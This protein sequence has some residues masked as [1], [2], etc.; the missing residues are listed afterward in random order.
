[1]GTD[2]QRD[3]SPAP[4]FAADDVAQV[5]A[6][7]TA[8]R[9]RLRL[10]S[11]V[12]GLIYGLIASAAVMGLAILL[13][14]LDVLGKTWLLRLLFLCPVGVA[15]TSI[16]ISLRRIDPLAVAALIDRSHGLHNRLSSALQFASGKTALSPTD[17]AKGLV[18]L[19]VHDAARVAQQV[20]PSLAAPWKKPPFLPL[21]CGLLALNGLLWLVRFER[22]RPPAKPASQQAANT[23][24]DTL[25]I[26]PELIAPERE[27]LLQKIAEAEQRGDKETAALL[28]EM[29]ELL[30]QV[31]RGELTR[32]QAFDRLSE[33]E[34]RIRTGS[35]ATLAE[36]E[37]RIHQAGSELSEAKLTRELGKALVKDDAEKAKA[38]L[39][40][41]AEKALAKA[42]AQDK[43]Q[44]ADA[45]ERAAKAM[46]SQAEDKAL[47][48]K[49]DAAD[50][51]D[52]WQ[53][54]SKSEELSQKLN[55]LAEEKRKVEEQLA[56][57][58]NDREAQR[59]L[60]QI[61]QQEKQL[62]E[63]L[64]QEQE[65]Q[66]Q[67]LAKKDQERK[68]LEQKREEL[69]EE[70]RR[71]K[72]KLTENPQDEESERRLKKTQRELEQL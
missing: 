44:M 15:L 25:Q 46:S 1:M 45:F 49:P 39:K 47:K 70:E 21:L 71:L 68:E 26:D 53:A 57:N 11:A 32:Q 20:Q 33:I 8:V 37:K 66:K 55:E 67:E 50:S 48:D 54:K 63:Q 40:E 52:Q 42:A 3:E 72:K 19:A 64:K 17:F 4:G 2:K 59:K 9:T 56:K 23:T 62:S 24:A 69:R 65:K 36:L 6:K 5:M 12:R 22:N 16:A 34:Q 60:E 31:E 35:D 43:Q 18:Q 41:L 38:E 58:P 61:K 28:R 29:L 27:D 14:R 30:R 7:V 10:Q 13:F 51:K